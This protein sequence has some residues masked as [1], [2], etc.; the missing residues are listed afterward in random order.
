MLPL[1]T[2]AFELSSA[3]AEGGGVEAAG[4]Y[5][6]L[7][8]P[9]GAP[10]VRPENAGKPRFKHVGKDIWVW[11][12]GNWH[13][14]TVPGEEECAA[15]GGDEA[16]ML[17]YWICDHLRDVDGPG[18]APYLPP[19][20]GWTKVHDLPDFVLEERPSDGGGTPRAL[21]RLLGRSSLAGGGRLWG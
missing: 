12:S 17:A 13:V 9:D 5:E 1:G 3:G 11:W 15:A 18:A 4:R 6:M 19:R 7:L 20:T 21:G 14:A 10:D 16:C 2:V 8:R